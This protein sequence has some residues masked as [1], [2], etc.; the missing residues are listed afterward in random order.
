MNKPV[1]NKPR[2]PKN[3]KPSG[4]GEHLL[5]QLH[6]PQQVWVLIICLSYPAGW[7]E[8]KIA[9][10]CEPHGSLW[11]FDISWHIKSPPTMSKGPQWVLRTGLQKVKGAPGS[12]KSRPL[13]HRWYMWLIPS[14]TYSFLSW[15]GRLMINGE[16]NC[17]QRDPLGKIYDGLD[18]ADDGYRLCSTGYWIM[19]IWCRR[20]R[21]NKNYISY[22]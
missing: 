3:P 15:I 19:K 7:V 22:I 18:Y 1:F 5:G 20:S 4:H 14:D 11:Q 21:I 8:Q 16:G 2:W 12:E 6:E 17:C 13:I 10:T 9:K